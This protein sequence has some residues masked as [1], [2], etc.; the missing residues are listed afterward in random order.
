MDRYSLHCFL[1]TSRANYLS[2]FLKASIRKADRELRWDESKNKAL[3]ALIR[4]TLVSPPPVSREPARP[5]KAG[6][7]VP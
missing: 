4:K 2:R 7:Q 5:R 6:R 1:E 3:L